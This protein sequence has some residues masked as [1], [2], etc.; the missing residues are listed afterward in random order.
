VDEQGQIA[1]SGHRVRFIAGRKIQFDPEGFLVDADD[2]SEEIAGTLARENRM[3]NLSE[4]QWL[5][6][7]F[8]RNYFLSHGKA[9]LNRELKA[10]TG[11]SLMELEG[12]FPGGIRQGARLLAG[13][14]NPRTCL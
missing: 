10:G 3:E 7:R 2:W 6:I 1:A 14:P 13:L 12:L 4:S 5:V 8:L 11:F 9:P